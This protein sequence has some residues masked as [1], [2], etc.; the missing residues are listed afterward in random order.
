MLEPTRRSAPLE[1]ASHVPGLAARVLALF[2]VA[3]LVLSAL[4]ASALVTASYDL[5]PNAAS[6]QVVR[7]VENW[8][9]FTASLGLERPAEW[10]EEAM[11]DI[12]TRRMGEEEF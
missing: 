4:N 5:P 7:L 9:A 12:R 10:A 1:I 2:A 6:E 11:Y 8:Q 3:M